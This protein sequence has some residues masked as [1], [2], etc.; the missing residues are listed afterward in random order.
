MTP[1][2]LCAAT[3]ANTERRFKKAFSRALPPRG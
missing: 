2:K 1:E 3:L